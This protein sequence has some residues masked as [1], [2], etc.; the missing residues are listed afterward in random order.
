LSADPERNLAGD[1][2]LEIEPFGYTQGVRVSERLARIQ[3]PFQNLE[4]I[5]T[6]TFG[7]CL[8]LDNA[9]QTSEWD[10]FMYHE[11]LVH[12]A[13]ITHPDPRRVLIIGGG[14]GGT[15]RRVLEHPDTEPIQVEIDETVIS[16]CREHIPA[17]SSGAYDNPRAK[18]VIADGFE[19][20]RAHPGEFD[21]VI[22]DS[23]DPIGPAV[24]LF[25]E[26]FYRDVYASL[27][28]D[29]LLVAQSNSPIHMR[30]QLQAQLANL[31]PVFPIVRTYVGLVP[32]YPGGVWSYT[33]ASKRYDPLNVS[34]DDVARRLQD[35]QITPRYY[36][37]AVHTSAFTLPGFI[38]ELVG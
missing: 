16:F 36:S 15:L 24:P 34:G 19:Y 18:I 11:M 30:A 14:D 38:A 10:E 33:I 22:V 7:R 6:D 3:T 29:G 2:Y 25:Q 20:M 27:A 26:P 37:P 9:L 4:I 12:T 23:T 5:N 28:A 1:W 13:L 31:R 8:V 32:L 35:A 17:I 21:V